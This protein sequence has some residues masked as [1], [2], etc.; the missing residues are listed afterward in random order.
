[1]ETNENFMNENFISG[2]ESLMFIDEDADTDDPENCQQNS[3]SE[4]KC[5]K[6]CVVRLD[7]ARYTI[8]IHYFLY[9]L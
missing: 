8:G 4:A 3:H 7:G 5:R 9:I 6:K 2:E 1:M